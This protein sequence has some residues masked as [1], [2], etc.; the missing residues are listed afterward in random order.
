MERQVS[1]GLSIEADWE[2]LASGPP[3][4]RACFAAIGISADSV[5]L[6]RADDMFVNRLR[7]KV[8]LSAYRLAEWLAWNWWRLRWEPKNHRS[9]WPFAHH[10]TTIGGGFI[11]PNITIYSDG[12][13]V[14]LSAKP[15]QPR[16]REPLRYIADWTIVL[17]ANA[18]ENAVSDFIEQVIGQLRAEKVETTN[19]D[20]VWADVRE[21]RLDEHVSLRRRF[22]ALLGFDPDEG[23]K[24]QIESLV[25]DASSLGVSAMNEVAADSP[26]NGSILAEPQL[27]QLATTIGV[28]VS[29][30]D[31][32]ALSNKSQ[33]P[34]YGKVAAWRRGV[35]AAS[36]LRAQESLGSGPLGNDRLAQL[37][38]ARKS[39]LD[40][41]RG[42]S[43][44]SFA[45]DKNLSSGS[46]VLRSR[47]TT[48][49]R[50]EL[51]RL[52]G[53][54]IAGPIDGKLRPATRAYTYRQQL[55]RSFAAE[56]LCP[57]DE[58][59][60]LLGEDLST[61]AIEEAA[62]HFEVS[63]LTVR[64]LLVNHRRLDRGDLEEEQ[65]RVIETDSEPLR[66]A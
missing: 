21:E 64:T 12:E 53:D 15:T 18:F 33:L 44:M 22:E 29:P 32:I 13:R 16:L 19:L 59:S 42:D 36:A 38:G 9:S 1:E 17:P 25:V 5:W 66:A 56:L 27:Q 41:N 23:D 65:G 58:L 37:A 54:R 50:F 43:R 4:E 26:Q 55:Q 35:E 39:I 45:L 6:T 8:H 62:A 57:F 3:E 24:D 60:D 61:E 34:A 14:V 11:W 46:I 51:A 48:G 30:S 31:A 52:L 49:R 40:Q 47:W 20:R 28:Q 10:L 2:A 63:E 7:D